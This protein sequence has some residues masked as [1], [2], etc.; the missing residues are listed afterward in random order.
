M[1]ICPDRI[2]RSY[3]NNE[4]YRSQLLSILEEVALI[5]RIERKEGDPLEVIY[6]EVKDDLEKLAYLKGKK[7]GLKI[8]HAEVNRQ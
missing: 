4:F 5:P 7:D 2:N 1:C 6:A 3:M 8:Y